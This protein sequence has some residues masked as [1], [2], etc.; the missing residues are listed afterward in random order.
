MS[1]EGQDKIMDLEK[2]LKDQTL[3]F[4]SKSKYLV[5]AL[6][7]TALIGLGLVGAIIGVSVAKNGDL[8]EKDS[9]IAAKDK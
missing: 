7:L 6:V 8:I 3:H 2:Q 9:L 5:I 4:K 1:Q